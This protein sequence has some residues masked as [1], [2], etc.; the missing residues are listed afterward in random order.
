MK[1]Y[2]I[3]Y[4]NAENGYKYTIATTIKHEALFEYVRAFKPTNYNVKIFKN[5]KNITEKVNKMLEKLWG[6]KWQEKMNEN[7]MKHMLHLISY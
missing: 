2:K 1:T 6:V 7:F 3:T 5:D 4:I